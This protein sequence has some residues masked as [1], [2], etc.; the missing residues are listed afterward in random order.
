MR[1]NPGGSTPPPRPPDSPESP[2]P[3]PAELD[4]GG[5]AIDEIMQSGFAGFSAS[6]AELGDWPAGGVQ[7]TKSC[8]WAFEGETKDFPASTSNLIEAS[9]ALVVDMLE[10]FPERKYGTEDQYLSQ[11]IY[12]WM[13]AWQCLAETL[14][15]LGTYHDAVSKT[16]DLFSSQQHSRFVA[17]DRRMQDHLGYGAARI[18]DFP[19]RRYP[20]AANRLSCN[21]YKFL[22]VIPL[23][24]GIDARY[25]L[26]KD[27]IPSLLTFAN[28]IFGYSGV[29][30]DTDQL[31]R[32]LLLFVGA[33]IVAEGRHF[34]AYDSW[35]GERYYQKLL[36]DAWR[37][38]SEQ[39]PDRA[40]S[41]WLE[42]LIKSVPQK[43]TEIQ[44][45]QLMADEA[46]LPS[47]QEK[48]TNEQYVDL[49]KGV[50][51]NLLRDLTDEELE[52]YFAGDSYTS[53]TYG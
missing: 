26:H 33:C 50:L 37:W 51:A 48:L 10:R 38:L 11:A 36:S 40:F 8:K 47:A 32:S 30:L 27:H 7:I 29:D 12:D 41:P 46:L 1:P 14:V 25:K 23:P 52:R 24:A 15:L 4:G 28:S 5:H 35:D 42:S 49:N 53:Y 20:Y 18:L 2:E 16:Q 6:V 3:P 19:Y 17:F 13:Y 21:I 43:W 31:S 45:K 9:Y 22:T 39:L 34:Y 44:G